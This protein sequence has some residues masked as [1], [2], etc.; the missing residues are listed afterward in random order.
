MIVDVLRVQR[1]HI[2][3]LHETDHL[4]SSEVTKRV[5]GQAQS[6]RQCFPRGGPFLSLCYDVARSNPRCRNQCSGANEIATG[7]AVLLRHA[8][9]SPSRTR[10]PTSSSLP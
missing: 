3:L 2:E 4:R 5:T 10:A 7:K 8:A 9:P 6:N 1:K